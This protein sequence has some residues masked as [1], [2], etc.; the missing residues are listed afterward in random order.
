MH[1]I[2]E[3]WHPPTAVDHAVKC[4]FFNRK[5]VNLVTASSS[6]LTVYHLYEEASKKVLAI[7]L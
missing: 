2:L 3:G 5:E 6:L 4:N 1:S 7:I